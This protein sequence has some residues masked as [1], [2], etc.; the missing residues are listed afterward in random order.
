MEDNKLEISQTPGV[1]EFE[2]FNISFP[3]F[4]N[5]EY[6]F[7]FNNEEP[8]VIVTPQN[9]EDLSIVLKPD[10]SGNITFLN[11][12]RSMS[13]KIYAREKQVISANA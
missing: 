9:K 6:V 10:T 12:D 7:Q 8:I 5:P 11:Q 2:N 1:F 3:E 13:F 4:E